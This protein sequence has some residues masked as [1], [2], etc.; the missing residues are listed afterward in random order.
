MVRDANL[1]LLISLPSRYSQ[2]DLM[3][4]VGSLLG[5]SAPGKEGACT[6]CACVA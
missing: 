6:A 1:K 4:S 3:V 5:K 2:I